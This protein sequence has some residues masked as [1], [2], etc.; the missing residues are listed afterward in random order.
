MSY[1]F[2]PQLM[3][4]P[5]RHGE[6]RYL[7]SM[8]IAAMEYVA[9]DPENSR[10]PQTLTGNL[11]MATGFIVAAVEASQLLSPASELRPAPGSLAFVGKIFRQDAKH[12]SLIVDLKV[13]FEDEE[14]Q[15]HF[16]RNENVSRALL[17][18]RLEGSGLEP[19][20]HSMEMPK[21]SSGNVLKDLHPNLNLENRELVS[22]I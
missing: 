20:A 9:Y 12:Q 10:L 22:T 3:P 13:W 18:E 16:L 17:M 7:Q 19:L 6:Y 1:S 21:N 2:G 5:D 14:G 4:K 11:P 8:R 15:T